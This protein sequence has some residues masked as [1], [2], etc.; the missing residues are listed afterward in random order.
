MSH[1]QLSRISRSMYGWRDLF[2]DH[3][4]MFCSNPRR[5]WT[6]WRINHRSIQNKIYCSLPIVSKKINPPSMLSIVP[7]A[8][9]LQIPQNLNWTN[10][11]ENHS[12]K[13][14]EK[15]IDLT[16]ISKNFIN[17]ISIFSLNIIFFVQLS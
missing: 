1:G 14:W 5:C 13:P 10:I 4:Q 7:L 15:C 6:K 2:R 9:V 16:E 17:Q 11:K 12:I 3:W 8:T